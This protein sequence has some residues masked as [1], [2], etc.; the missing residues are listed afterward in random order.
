VLDVRAAPR[1]GRAD[2]EGAALL[3]RAV[4][5]G[6]TLMAYPFDRDE[7]IGN[8][9]VTMRSEYVGVIVNNKQVSDPLWAWV[10]EKRWLSAYQ[11]PHDHHADGHNKK[12][13]I[14]ASIA[15]GGATALDTYNQFCREAAIDTATDALGLE[16]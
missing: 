14:P 6:A 1:H 4:R 15:D 8:W 13:R 2:V 16:E 10:V 11:N 5:P 12:V 7:M 9:N 3:R